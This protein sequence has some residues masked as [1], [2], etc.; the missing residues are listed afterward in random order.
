MAQQPAP[1]ETSHLMP[2]QCHQPGACRESSVQ[3]GLDGFGN[4]SSFKNK[5][6]WQEPADGSHMSHHRRAPPCR[7]GAGGGGGAVVAALTCFMRHP[8]LVFKSGALKAA[9][10]FSPPHL[11]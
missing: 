7:S 1:V 8:I 5:S 4:F 3:S 9:Q 2:N 6:G 11:V 10:P